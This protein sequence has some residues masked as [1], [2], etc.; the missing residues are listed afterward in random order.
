MSTLDTAPGVRGI[1]EPVPDRCSSAALGEVDFVLAPGVA[2]SPRCERLGYGGGYYDVLLA[3]SSHRLDR[4]RGGLRAA[5]RRKP[6]DR[7][8]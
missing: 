6:A 2:F 3:G 8:G 7:A 1:R 4:H 5:D